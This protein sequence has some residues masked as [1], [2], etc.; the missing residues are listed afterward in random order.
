MEFNLSL[1]PM[2]FTNR[3]RTESLSVRPSRSS[4]EGDRR[5]ITQ[6]EF[7]QENWVELLFEVVAFPPPLEYGTTG[8]ALFCQWNVFPTEFWSPVGITWQSQQRR[9]ENHTIDR[10][11]THKKKRTID[12]FFPLFSSLRTFVFF[13]QAER[14]QMLRLTQ[15]HF[16][17]ISIS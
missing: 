11:S 15:W 1:T 13:C 5:K 9:N 2:I 17:F 4:W 10:G 6:H 7:R 12:W 8:R 14:G 16:F 3:L